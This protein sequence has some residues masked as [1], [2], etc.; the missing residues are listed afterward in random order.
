MAEKLSNFNVYKLVGNVNQNADS[1]SAGMGLGLI[2][3][4]SSKLAG[5]TNV[6]K[7]GTSLWQSSGHL[8]D[9]KRPLICK[10]PLALLQTA[11]QKSDS[12]R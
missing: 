1:D 4:I 5:N 12:P 7:Q 3:C 11:F 2:F 9:K 8:T 10:Y 6:V